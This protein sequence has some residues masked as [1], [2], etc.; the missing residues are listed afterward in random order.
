MRGLLIASVAVCTAVATDE[1]LEVEAS[2][3][4]QLRRSPLS[5]GK[6]QH[7]DLADHVLCPGS[8]ISCQ[9]NECCPGIPESGGATFPCPSADSDYDGCTRDTKVEDCRAFC[10]YHDH[11]SC[12]GSG[13]GCQGNE[14]CPGIPETN[15]ASFPCPNADASYQKCLNHTKVEDC[16]APGN[17]LCKNRYGTTFPCG[18]GDCC[19]DI[20]MARGGVC[21]HNWLGHNFACAAGDSCCG[22]AC[23]S[24]AGKCCDGPFGT[25][26]PASTCRR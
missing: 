18:N 21:C 2:C 26:Y 10:K 3:A 24:A 4:L 20:C 17:V 8:G 6:F 9:G 11:V 16:R 19:G 1:A 13:V 15:H 22:N 14:C 23:A 7:C 25:K 5:V 12:P